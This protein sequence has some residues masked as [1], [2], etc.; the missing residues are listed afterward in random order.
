MQYH[1]NYIFFMVTN[2]NFAATLYRAFLADAKRS[3]YAHYFSKNLKFMPFLRHSSYKKAPF[4]QFNGNLQTIVPSRRIVSG[5]DYERE[6]IET[7]DKD[8]L[9]L[10][11][12]DKKSRKLLILTHGL[13]GASDRQYMRGMAKMFAKNGFDVLAWNCRSCSGEM[14]RAFR[15]YNHGEIGDIEAVLN[16]A[17]TRKNYDEVS[18]VGFSMGGNVSLKF[19]AVCQHPSVKKVVAFSSPLEMRT[20]TAVLDYPSRF[21]YQHYFRKGILPKVKKKAEMFPHLLNMAEVE[22]AKTWEAEQH[23]FFVKINGYASIDDFYEKGSA[24]NFIPSLKIPTLIVQAQND[25]MLTLE[26]SPIQLAENHR[27]IHLETPRVGGHCGFMLPNDKAHTW[28]EYRALEF[29][30]S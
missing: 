25:P 17:L 21:I 4:G 7:F 27:F 23:L 5:V 26:C 11:W 19:A 13:E 30:L 8:F 14:N 24:L 18:L 6:R 12:I 20:S 22:A 16:H 29:V 28:A 3:F 1:K 9:D 15:L 10:D 2:R